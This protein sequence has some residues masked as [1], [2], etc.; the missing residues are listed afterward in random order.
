MLFCIIIYAS[1]TKLPLN[2]PAGLVSLVIGTALAWILIALSDEVHT[3]DEFQPPPG[4]VSFSFSFPGPQFPILW[5]GLQNG[6][7]YIPVIFP[8][9]LVNLVQN[10]ANIETAHTMDDRFSR[11]QSL[12]ADAM[13]TIVSACFGNP[14]P[15]GIFIGQSAFKASGIRTGYA[16]GSALIL[17]ALGFSGAMTAIAHYIP[18]PAG[19]G[20]LMWIGILVTK[21]AFAKEDNAFDYSA[22]VVIGLLPPIAAWALAFV[23]ATLDAMHAAIQNTSGVGATEKGLIVNATSLAVVSEFL[24][25]EGTFIYGIMSLSQGYLLIGIILSSTSAYVLDKRFGS[26]ALWMLIGAVFSFFGV[27]HGFEF[28][29]DSVK[30]QLVRPACNT[31]H[32][33]CTVL[34][35]SL[36]LCF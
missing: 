16:L 35:C 4:N 31:A 33:F 36:T 20:F 25:S 32:Q 9:F 1:N 8:M 15:T 28:S 26:A 17:A 23:T 11:W 34:C 3:V 19:V 14:F 12:V 18:L 21:Q 5:G 6:W 29:P 22:A 2:L 10:L 13:V 7:A 30:P 24:S 27:I